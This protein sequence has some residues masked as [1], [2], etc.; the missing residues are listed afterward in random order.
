MWRKLL[1]FLIILL[2][3]LLMLVGMELIAKAVFS[4]KLQSHYELMR[5]QP[6][7]YENAPYWSPSLISESQ[8][9]TWSIYISDDDSLMLVNDFNGEFIN[10]ENGRRVTTNQPIGVVPT[11]WLVGGS[12]LFNEEVPDEYT[13]ASYLQRLIGNRY[14]VENYGVSSANITQ[15]VARLR[16][17]DVRPN[18]LVVFMDGVNEILVG[19]YYGD[20]TSAI[21]RENR[22]RIEQMPASGLLE[23]FS[24]LTFVRFITAMSMPIPT[25]LQNIDTVEQLGQETANHYEQRLLEAQEFTESQGATFVHFLQPH[26]FTLQTLSEYEQSLNRNPHIMLPGLETAYRSGYGYLEA[27]SAGLPFSY[28]I[29]DAFDDVRQNGEELFLDFCH[30]THRGNELLAEA[31]GDVINEDY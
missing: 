3:T 10:I 8:R 5:S 6:P 21:V 19:I 20:H 25:H 9:A 11:L 27:V 12:T 7:P 16:T 26:L 28:D 13:V 31:M 15:E 18:D 14:R 1:Q 30:V 24:Y 2:V 4:D 23:T 17:L 22:N 29:S